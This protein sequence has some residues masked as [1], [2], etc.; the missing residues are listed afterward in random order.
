MNAAIRLKACLTCL[1][2]MVLTLGITQMSHAQEELVLYLDFEEGSG[3]PTDQVAPAETVTLEGGAEY[4]D[5]AAKGDY[6]MYFDALANSYLEVAGQNLALQEFTLDFWFKP[7]SINGATWLVNKWGI[8]NDAGDYF[9]RTNY[10]IIIHNPNGVIGGVT[11]DEGA[12]GGSGAP[13]GAN[14]RAGDEA[15]ESTIEIGTW[16]NAIFVANADTQF[17]QMRDLEGNLLGEGGYSPVGPLAENPDQP[18]RIAWGGSNPDNGVPRFFHGHIDDLYV[19][20]Y[21]RVTAEGEYIP[22]GEG[23]A[24]DPPGELPSS[25]MLEQNYPNPFNPSTSISFSL[26]SAD[27]VTLKVFDT[28]GREVATLIDGTRTAG[29]HSVQFDALGLSNGTYLYRLE[30]PHELRSRTMILMK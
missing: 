7:D 15:G 8:A 30:T 11:W 18:F 12:G 22:P 5:D 3:T 9:P 29:E 1:L 4:S 6:S 10:G 24:A 27:H 17:F 16:H 23:T 13:T 20:N 28:L 21:A 2:G 25:V 19:Y 14:Q 26:P